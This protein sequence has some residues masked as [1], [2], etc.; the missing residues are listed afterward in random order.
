MQNINK[1]IGS[2]VELQR[3]IK[4]K[5]RKELGDQV[6]VTQ[7]QIRNYEIG[8]QRMTIEKLFDISKVLKVGFLKLLP[9]ELFKED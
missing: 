5:T 3:K 7:Q 4:R 2:E 1:K 6:G 8:K 9:E